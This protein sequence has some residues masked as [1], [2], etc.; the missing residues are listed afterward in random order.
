[1]TFE[2]V[3]PRL[4][5]Y[6][7]DYAGYHRTPGNQLMH[8]IGLPMIVITTLG[9][10]SSI[11]ILRIDLG[12]AL[13]LLGSLAYL[14]LDWKIALPFSICA[15]GFYMMGRALPLGWNLGL[16]TLGW[17]LQFI[18]HYKYEKKSPAFYK[19]ITH[20]LIGPL[21]L[22]VKLVRYGR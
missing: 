11:E 2:N 21:W 8:A 19:N 16:W 4:F 18:G 12:V 20:L 13:W 1:M 17:I 7:N 15:L 5:P 22:F 6:L 10:F 3:G 14:Y 9:L